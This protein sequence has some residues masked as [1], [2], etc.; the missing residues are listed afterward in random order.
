L[1]VEGAFVAVVYDDHEQ[2]FSFGGTIS[3][4]GDRFLVTVIHQPAEVV[5]KPLVKELLVIA[6]ELTDPFPEAVHFDGKDSFY[7]L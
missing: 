7:C 6:I 4:I 5:R 3:R 1:L 2:L